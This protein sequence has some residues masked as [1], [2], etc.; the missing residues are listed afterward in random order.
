MTKKINDKKDQ[1]TTELTSSFS[2]GRKFLVKTKNIR[3][4]PV[5]PKSFKDYKV[6]IEAYKRNLKSQ[7]WDEKSENRG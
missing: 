7:K 4:I 5:L 1:E 6:D 3:P 2:P